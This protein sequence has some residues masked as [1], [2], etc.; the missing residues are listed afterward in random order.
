MSSLLLFPCLAE[1]D[2][3]LLPSKHSVVVRRE[4]AALS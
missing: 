3:Y 2:K 4:L 1:A